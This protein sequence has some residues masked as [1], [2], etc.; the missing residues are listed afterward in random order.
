MGPHPGYLGGLLAEQ[1][2]LLR[3]PNVVAFA[4]N[5]SFVSHRRSI[6]GGR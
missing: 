6:R 2:V 1:L 3:E 4:T 5:I